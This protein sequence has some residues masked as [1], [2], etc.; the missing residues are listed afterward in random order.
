MPRRAEHRGVYKE[1]KM[2][3]IQ[4]CKKNEMHDDF[5]D[6][7]SR[8]SML[9]GAYE[10]A[11]TYRCTLKAGQSWSPEVFPFG[12]RMQIFYFVSG[13]GYI[14]MD[15][16][17][18]NINEM[19]V[20]VPKFDQTRFTICAG[21]DMVFLQFVGKMREYDIKRFG[22]IGITLPRFKPLR[23]CWTY[24]EDFKTPGIR[25]YMVVEHRFFGRYSLGAVIG[26]GPSTVGMHMHP[27]LL[28]WCY[29]LPGAKYSYTAEDE[30]IQVEDGDFT[31]IPMGAHHRVDVKPGD[32]MDYIWFELCVEGYK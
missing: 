10:D 4:I 24:D 22:A 28:Q 13:S 17:A 23:D 8:V 14:A 16:Y 21:T 6:G 2:S 29:A 7:L 1:R 12:D 30:T 32:P 11:K 31:F 18:N 25:S 26:N 9:P 20:F 27:D 5:H 19:S 15:G 3:T